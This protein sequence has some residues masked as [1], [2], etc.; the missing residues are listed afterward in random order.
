MCDFQ[1]MP[2]PFL[3]SVFMNVGCA[4]LGGGQTG[5][6]AALLRDLE[7]NWSLLGDRR[8]LADMDIEGGGKRKGMG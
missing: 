3:R 1:D 5:Q 6:W 4:W 7:N 2:G 8:L